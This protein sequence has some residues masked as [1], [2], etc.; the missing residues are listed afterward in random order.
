MYDQPRIGRSHLAVHTLPVG[1]VLYHNTKSDG[2]TT[3]Q[4][5]TISRRNHERQCTRNQTIPSVPHRNVL[6]RA[7]RS[8]GVSPAVV[9]IVTRSAE[10]RRSGRRSVIFERSASESKKPMLKTTRKANWT[11]TK[12]G[13]D[14]CARKTPL[15]E[16]ET[17]R[18]N[19]CLGLRGMLQKSTTMS[20]LARWPIITPMRVTT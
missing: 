15:D 11:T 8:H 19:R 7:K 12:G 4:L 5:Q 16:R 17:R 14:A 9:K 6:L 10:K 18:I 13:H 2:R 20:A 3:Q 1:S